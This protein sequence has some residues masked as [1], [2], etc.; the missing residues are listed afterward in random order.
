LT[1]SILIIVDEIMWLLSRSTG[2][3]AVNFA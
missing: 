3:W 2:P 1:A